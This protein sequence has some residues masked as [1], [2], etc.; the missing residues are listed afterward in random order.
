MNESVEL[1][2][3]RSGTPGA[4]PV[5]ILHGL[6]G[7]ADNWG[8]I[9]RELAEPSDPGAPP[10][11]V[12]L[13]DLRDHGRSP[14]TT[15]ISYPLMAA[16]VHALVQQLGLRDIVLVGHSMGGKTAMTFAQRWPE[17][18]KQLVVIDIGPREHQNNQGHIIEALRTA[19]LSHGRT[20]REV[21]EHIAHYVKEPGV[22]QFLLKNLYWV[23]EGTLAWRMNVE[24]LGREIGAI[25]A[26]IGPERVQ[27]PSIFI[28]GGQSNYILREDIPAIQEQFT[29]ARIET[30]P[31]AGHWV[32]AQAPEEVI[33]YIRQAASA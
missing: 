10:L 29:K 13:V 24:L 3:R 19:D 33:Q 16:D 7:T 28:R 21:E 30:V 26:A 22:V 6:F 8:S 1:N 20:R 14:H 31:Y 18:L 23:E 12:F 11:D 4:T 5:V 32:H 2:Y 15:A 17:L 9:G 25:L 27:V